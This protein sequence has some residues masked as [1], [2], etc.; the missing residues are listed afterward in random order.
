M[1]IIKLI[2]INDWNSQNNRIHNYLRFGEIYYSKGAII[3]AEGEKCYHIPGF[4]NTITKNGLKNN[5]PLY[6]C[7]RFLELSDLDELEIHSKNN[8]YE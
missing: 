5:M 3:N 1:D 4:P 6:Q 7:N 2:C 8:K